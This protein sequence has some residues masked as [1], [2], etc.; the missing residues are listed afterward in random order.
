M[1]IA[2]LRQTVLQVINEVERL[3]NVSTSTALTS[4]TF[5]RVLLRLLNETV[6]ELSDLGDWQELYD[7]ILV[8]ASSSVVEYE[9]HASGGLVQRVDEI[10]FNN[11]VAP[12]Y[13]KTPEDMRR[14]QRLSSFGPPRQ[15]AII[16]VNASSGNPLFRPWPVPGSS[17]NNQTF[18]VC[19][20]IKPPLYTT[21][22]GSIV[23]PFPANV[24]IQGLYSK[25]LLEENGGE[26]TR[27]FETSYAAYI[28][29]RAE[30][31]K[32]FNADTGTDLQIVPTGGWG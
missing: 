18:R 23:I 5:T 31:Q 3:L 29:M 11:S 4:N 24:V 7:E 10:T 25:A 20:F 14:L 27:E 32:R 6:D 22:D 21:S 19:Y 30:A 12:L 8:T 17:Q 13:V 9:V 26:P 1:A 16:G 2:A 15:F 28:R